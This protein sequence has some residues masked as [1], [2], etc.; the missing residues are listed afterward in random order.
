MK[1]DHRNLLKR[2]LRKGDAAGLKFRLISEDSGATSE[3]RH[4]A[5]HRLTELHRKRFDSMEKP[6]F[7]V[8]SDVQRFH[9]EI[10]EQGDGSVAFEFI[11]CT[12]DETVI[13]SIYSVATR[14]EYVCLMTGFDPEH[15]RL[16]VGFLLM[17]RAVLRA[18]ELK[19]E[20]FDM[21]VGAEAYKS[22]WSRD[23]YKVYSLVVKP[24]QRLMH[25]LNDRALRL[26]KSV[27]RA[28]RTARANS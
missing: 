11:E 9:A 20:T 15:S 3:D 23:R 5:L 27:T 13:G 18:I 1:S 16:S 6:S 19:L 25:S 10:A 24:R 2:K 17:Y 26:L 28:T 7:F 8:Q 22:W 12:L 21:K 4:A 14:G